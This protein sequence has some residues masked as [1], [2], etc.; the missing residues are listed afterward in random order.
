[1]RVACF[2]VTRP[3]SLGGPPRFESRTFSQGF[4]SAYDPD[5]RGR[6][7]IFEKVVPR[8][9]S[10][11]PRDLKKML[12][13]YVVGQDRAKKTICSIVFNHA[14]KISYRKY[15]AE[16]MRD[17]DEKEARQ[18]AARERRLAAELQGIN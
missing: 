7:P 15:L 6:G 16:Q 3:L 8:A 11:Y 2:T 5:E 12:D 17:R 18:A 9:A 1:M 4:T 14:Q 10:F 13:D